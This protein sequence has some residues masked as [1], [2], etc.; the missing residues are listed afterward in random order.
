MSISN[1]Q[2]KNLDD[3]V[4]RLRQALGDDLASVVLY[5]SAASQDFHADFSDLNILC[6]TRKLDIAELNAVQPA[7]SWWSQLKQP[8]PLFFSLEE[9][10]RSTDVFTIEL[11]DMKSRNRMLFG[12]DHLSA[13]EVPMDL[14]GVQ[15]ERELRTNLLRLRQ[16]YLSAN[17]KDAQ[18]ALLV[19]AFSSFATLFRHA[20]IALGKE[21]PHSRRQVIDTLAAQLEFDP[22]PFHAVLDVRE[23]KRKKSDVDVP[24]TFEGFLIGVKRVTGEVDRRLPGPRA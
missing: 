10:E 17:T 3:L 13:L 23:G 21:L 8:Q 5:G 6:L 24:T 15:L 2:Q 22:A 20:L 12:A 9:L 11:L 19:D 18:L 1:A 7:L 16:H 4:A 14:H